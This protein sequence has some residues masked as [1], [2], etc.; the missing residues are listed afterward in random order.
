MHAAHAA[1]CAQKSSFV[2]VGTNVRWRGSPGVFF[3][4][5]ARTP[6]KYDPASS[7]SKGEFAPGDVI[8]LAGPDG[9][10]F[11][12]GKTALSSRGPPRDP[13]S[14]SPYE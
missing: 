1:V 9:A 11:A 3:V 8:A 13:V 5:R 2:L 6:L 7:G 10:V 4:H 14:L 12:R